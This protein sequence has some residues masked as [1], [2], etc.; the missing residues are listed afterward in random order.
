[1]LVVCAILQEQALDLG[2]VACM[3]DPREARQV[4]PFRRMEFANFFRP[5]TKEEIAGL[6]I[7]PPD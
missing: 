3:I 1:M 4:G 5:L 7:A 6:T 2:M